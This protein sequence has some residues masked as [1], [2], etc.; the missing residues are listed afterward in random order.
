LDTTTGKEIMLLCHKAS[1]ERGQT[2]VAVTHAS[3]VKEYT[4]R[5][6]YMRDGKLYGQVLDEEFEE[7][8]S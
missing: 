5:V 7:Q 4:D 8:A 2:V 6:L 1:K 3:Y